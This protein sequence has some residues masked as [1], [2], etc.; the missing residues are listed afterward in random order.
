M[1]KCALLCCWMMLLAGCKNPERQSVAEKSGANLLESRIRQE[2]EVVFIPWD[3]KLPEDG[4]RCTVRFQQGSRIRLYLFGSDIRDYVGSFNFLNDR[5]IEA[6]IK[7]DVWPHPYMFWP[8]ML[9]RRE[10]EDLL[11]YREDGTTW[12]HDLYPKDGSTSRRDTWP[13][14]PESIDGFWPLRASKNMKAEQ[15]HAAQP[16][17]R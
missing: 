17:L 11:L 4:S 3:G 5:L 6:K 9:L 16:S 14:Y 1:K 13:F 12:W 8:R 2:K 15:G 10:G 7:S